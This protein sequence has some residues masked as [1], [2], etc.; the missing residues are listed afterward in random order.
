MGFSLVEE[1]GRGVEAKIQPSAGGG[2]ATSSMGAR[3]GYAGRVGLEEAGGLLASEASIV[4]VPVTGRASRRAVAPP[5]NSRLADPSSIPASD[6]APDLDPK[7]P[8]CSS[9][10]VA[11]VPLAAVTSATAESPLLPQLTDLQSS[12]VAVPSPAS[13]DRS[14]LSLNHQPSACAAIE[15]TPFLLEGGKSDDSQKRM[16]GED[17]EAFTQSPTTI[18]CADLGGAVSAIAALP[19]ALPVGSCLLRPETAKTPAVSCSG[20]GSEESQAEAA[21]AASGHSGSR[22]HQSASDG[23]YGPIK[24]RIDIEVR[25]LSVWVGGALKF[26]FG[27]SAAMPASCTFVMIA[28]RVPPV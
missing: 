7:I 28:V 1:D 21:A 16:G 14:S 26:C 3:S 20:G 25:G 10:R 13:I 4:M 2:D 19:A 5:P 24:P 22:H 11:A 9:S 23:A 18:A 17:E 12:R 6:P 27:E 8:T 15:L